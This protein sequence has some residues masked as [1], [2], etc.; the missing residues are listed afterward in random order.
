M[1]STFQIFAE[2]NSAGSSSINAFD[3]IPNL[4]PEEVSDIERSKSKAVFKTNIKNCNI[5]LN[6]NFQGRSQLALMNLGE[7][8]YLLRAEKNGYKF[9]ERFVYIERGKAKTFYLELE[10]N[11]EDKTEKTSEEVLPQAEAKAENDGE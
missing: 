6:G 11:E 10:P 7:G 8:Y 2:E 9:V 3:L 5:L 4:E 1:I